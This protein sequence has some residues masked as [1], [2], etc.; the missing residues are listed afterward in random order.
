MVESNNTENIE[1]LS[2]S[3]LVEL[4]IVTTP[5][6]EQVQEDMKNFA[7]QLKPYP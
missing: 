5:G 7:E 2:Q 1:P 4:S 3:Y 6:Q